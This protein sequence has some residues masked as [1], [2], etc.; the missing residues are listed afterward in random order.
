MN[1]ASFCLLFHRT[2]P[3]IL[4]E[5]KASH[6]AKLLKIVRKAYFTDGHSAQKEIYSLTCNGLFALNDALSV[7]RTYASQSTQAFHFQAGSE[8]IC[9]CRRLHFATSSAFFVCEHSQRLADIVAT[10]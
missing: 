8:A 6:S 2:S 3:A 7:R 5:L 9:Y 1:A 10:R 4:A